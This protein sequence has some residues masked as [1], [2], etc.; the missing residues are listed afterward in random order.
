MPITFHQLTDFVN[1]GPAY[2]ERRHISQSIKLDLRNKLRRARMRRLAIC[3]P[4]AFTSI[5]AVPGEHLTPSGELSTKAA[6]RTWMD[7]LPTWDF[8]S[9]NELAEFSAIANSCDEYR[10]LVELICDQDVHFELG[11]SKDMGGLT[12]EASAH[13]AV[14]DSIH[15]FHFTRE[16]NSA[17]AQIRDLFQVERLVWASEVFGNPVGSIF[18]V[19]TI[20]PYRVRQYRFHPAILEAAGERVARWTASLVRQMDVGRWPAHLPP[21]LLEPSH[22]KGAK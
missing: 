12:V 22:L 7:S 1:G 20:E 9:P 13:I 2:Y 15:N 4:D 18:A 19:E 8:V 11:T 14:P 16:F 17:V 3:Q 5:P 10:P 21:K 6:T